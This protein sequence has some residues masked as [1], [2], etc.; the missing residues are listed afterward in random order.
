MSDESIPLTVTEWEEWGNPHEKAYYDYMLSYSPMNNV[1]QQAY[2]PMLLTAGLNDSRV[3]YWEISKFTQRLREGNT[4]TSDILCKTDLSTG[5][6]S[7]SD[8]YAYIKDK[9]F[10]Y[11]WLLEQLGAP[12]KSPCMPASAAARGAAAA[13]GAGGKQGK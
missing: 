5:H 3:P 11:A 4:G 12:L 10:S 2:P 1:K 8:R 6:F 13:A 7:F 9:A